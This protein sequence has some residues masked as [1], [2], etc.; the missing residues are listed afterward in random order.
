LPPLGGIYVYVN[1]LTIENWKSIRSLSLN[2]EPGVNVLV[3]A[4]AA[5]KTNILE[6]VNFLY[7]SLVEAPLRTPYISHL[8]EYWSGL[9]LIYMKDPGLPVNIGLTM[10]VYQKSPEGWDK[11]E[12]GFTVTYHYEPA[13]DTLRPSS[14]TLTLNRDTTIIVG[15]EGVEIVVRGRLARDILERGVYEILN[16]REKLGDSALY[17]V[18]EGPVLRARIESRDSLTSPIYAPSMLLYYHPLMRVSRINSIVIVDVELRYRLASH[19]PRTVRVPFWSRLDTSRGPRGYKLDLRETSPTLYWALRRSPLAALGLLLHAPDLLRNIV[20]LRH[21]DIGSLN[22]PRRFEGRTRLD[23][24]ARNL[25]EVIMALRGRKGRLPLLEEAVSRAFPGFTLRVESSH[26]RVFLVAEERGLELPPPNMPDGL[27]KLAALAVALESG[28]LI[29]L[30]D[31]IENSMHAALLEIVY[32][33]LNSSGIP[34]LA[35]SHSPLF[36]DL[37]GP[38]RIILVRRGQDGT[39]AER[40]QDPQSLRRLLEEEG[41]ALS[42]HVLQGLTRGP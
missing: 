19:G 32:D 29:L 34:V 10:E 11:S 25:A 20:F 18:E 26:G 21:P 36:I 6:A 16:V 7:K 39:T 12:A 31:E 17:T 27:I 24:R 23:P 35:A 13:N 41:V 4:N 9:D 5:G 14:Y 33:M 3:G 22:E 28:P 30:I 2:L 42:D 8:P 1:K 40:I 37:A 38:E 15:E